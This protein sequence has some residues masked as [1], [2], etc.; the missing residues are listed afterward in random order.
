MSID[1]IDERPLHEGVVTRKN[2]GQY[3][4]QKNGR[5]VQCTISNKLRKKLLYP[6]ADPAS[7]GHYSVQRVED[8]DVVDPVAVGD[9]VQFIDLDDGSGHIIEVLPR[10]SQL[11]R[12][13]AGSAA[14]RADADLRM[15]QVLVANVDQ[16]VAVFAAARPKPKWHLLDRYLVIAEAAWV[17]AIICITKLDLV[18]AD[19]LTP[20]LERYRAIGYPVLLT[21]TMDTRGIDAARETLTGKLSVLMG[22][23][24]VGK[25]SLLNAIEPGLGLRVRAVSSGKRGK[26][27]HTTTHLELFPLEGGG[28]VVDTPGM[29]EFALWNMDSQEIAACFPEMRPY[30]G[31]CKFGASCRH[32][33]EP[34]CAVK[35]ALDAG[36]ISRPRYESYL[37]LAEEMA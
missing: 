26:G 8:I 3:L 30:L 31:T 20:I 10:K 24:G 4:V 13:A 15:E 25:T 22:K 19:K 2:R 5:G 33:S 16:V 1:T 7:L 37:K 21:S 6:L 14:R 29:R 27:R 12:A 9:Q 18:K 35:A 36:H 34:G 23:S 17:Q 28:G 11:S 32:D